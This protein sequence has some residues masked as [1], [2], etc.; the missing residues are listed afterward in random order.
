MKWLMLIATALLTTALVLPLQGLATDGSTEPGTTGQAFVTAPAPA[1]PLAPPT[2]QDAP[3]FV[4]KAESDLAE[5]TER[6][7]RIAWMALT[8]ITDDTDW[9]KTKVDAEMTQLQVAQAKRAAL[10]DAF[11][12]DPV[13]RRKLELLKRALVYPASDVPGAA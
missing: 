1:A 11:R 9:L 12:V 13:T 8:F 3:D 10:F 4:D 7:N 6:S 5:I 2:A